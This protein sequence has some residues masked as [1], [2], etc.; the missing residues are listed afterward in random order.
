VRQSITATIL[1]TIPT[2]EKEIK[3]AIEKLGVTVTF[4]QVGKPTHRDVAKDGE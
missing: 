1:T 2:D 4:V 3:D